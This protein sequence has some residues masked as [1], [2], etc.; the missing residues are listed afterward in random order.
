MADF[1]RYPRDSPLVVE[2]YARAGAAETAYLISESRAQIVR[3]YLVARFQRQTTLTGVMAMSDVA[4]GSPSGD[5]RW[6]GIALTLFVR[7]EALGVGSR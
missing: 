3:D 6:A 2:G 1:L 5:D 7:N 4:P